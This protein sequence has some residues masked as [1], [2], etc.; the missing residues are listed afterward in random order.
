MNKLK[1]SRLDYE[2]HLRKDIENLLL[3]EDFNSLFNTIKNDSDLLFEIRKGKPIV[4]YKGCM[5]IKIECSRGKLNLHVDPNYSKRQIEGN[6]KCEF[7]TTS[8]KLL[9]ELNENCFD[10]KRWNESLPPLKKCITDFRKIYHNVERQQQ[11]LIAKTNNDFKNEI[12]I[13]DTEYGV[14]KE[15]KKESKLC[16]FDMVGIKRNN[17]NKYDIVLIELKVGK[18]AINGKK[19]L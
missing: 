6:K 10:Y 15:R 8:F 7:D 18:G 12:I 19:P 11:Q 2:Q 5:I 14:R 3:K 16:V 9:N 13:L 1:E 4:Y 17:D